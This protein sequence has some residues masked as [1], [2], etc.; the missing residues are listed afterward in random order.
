MDLFGAFYAPPLQKPNWVGAI[1][2]FPKPVILDPQGQ[3]I[4]KALVNGMGFKAV[5]G[6]RMGKYIAVELDGSLK[7]QEAQEQLTAMCKDLL[8]NEVMEEFSF[9]LARKE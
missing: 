7:Q 6:V 3:A 2:V 9:S 8:A 1:H 5:T 4:H